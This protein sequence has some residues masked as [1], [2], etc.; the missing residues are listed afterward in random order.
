MN[1]TAI[2]VLIADDQELVRMG[3]RLILDAQPGIEVVGETADGAACV[4]LARRLRPDVC[5]VDVRMP[6]LDGL[7]VTRALAGPGV[8]SPMRVVVITTFDQ[9][10]YV[11]TALR[12]GA[13]GFLLKDAPPT[14]LVE[15]VRAAARGDALVSPAVTVRL[16]KHLSATRDEPA[17]ASRLT[18]RELDVARL[19]A[20]GRTNQEICEQLVV[21]LS[22]VK[23]HLANI[24]QKIDARNRVEI[25]A[26]A[27]ES[28]VVR[29]R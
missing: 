21:S 13:C 28:G 29:E 9:D 23:T 19:V 12:N 27:W 17:V 15:A 16:L 6:K 18:E 20:V 11:H 2:R 7:D 10:D 22:T 25:A 3:F 24:Q 1:D 26:W 14:L 8:H 5:L 4:E